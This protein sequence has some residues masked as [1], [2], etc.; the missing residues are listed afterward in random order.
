MPYPVRYSA[1]DVPQHLVQRGHSRG[2]VFFSDDDRLFFLAAL[3]LASKRYQ[4]SVYA[5]VL[6]TNHVHLLVQPRAPGAI[7]RTLQ[8]VGRRF[9][10]YV[11]SRQKRSGTI[12]ERRHHASLILSERYIAV[13]HAYIELNPV[14]AG[15]VDDPR[16]YR[17]SSC[18][19][20]SGT[21]V[22][23]VITESPMFSASGQTV[24]DRRA[25]HA[26]LLNAGVERARLERIRETVR[27]GGPFED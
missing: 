21:R 19:H 22:D 26:N 11:N 18:Q 12:W 10:P 20:Y 14:R 3:D 23:P 4:L 27:L 15:M 13:C 17:W 9:V 24:A 5:Y 25:V 8:S 1:I 7:P 2:A 16:V 6:M